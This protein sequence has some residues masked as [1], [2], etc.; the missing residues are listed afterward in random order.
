MTQKDKPQPESVQTGGGTYIRGSVHTDGGDFIGRD[1][2]VN[3][4]TNITQTFAPI[5]TQIEIHPTLPVADKTDLKAEVKELE[6]ELQKGEQADESFLERR[7]RNIKRTAPDILEVILATLA[8][9]AAGFGVIAA[10]VAA[11]MKAAAG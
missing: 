11:K 8:N 6:T 5:Y 3:A 4:Q 1:K 9:P 10:K 2:I 7:L